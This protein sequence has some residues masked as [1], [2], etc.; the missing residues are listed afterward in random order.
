MADDGR[1]RGERI[2]PTAERVI[3]APNFG[4]WPNSL[5]DPEVARRFNQLA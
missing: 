2:E 3:M 1:I 4:D 5:A